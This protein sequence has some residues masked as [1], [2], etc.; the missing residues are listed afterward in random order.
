L[1]GD[2][3]GA[4]IAVIEAIDRLIDFK[5]YMV[6]KKHLLDDKG[7]R[8][9]IINGY[10]KVQT[11]FPDSF[12][13]KIYRRIEEM[14][15]NVGNLGNNILPLVPEIQAVFSHPVVHGVLTS[16]LG[17]NYVMHP[18][19]Y[20]HLNRPGSDGQNFHK[21]TYEGDEQVRRHRC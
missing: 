5:K 15:E 9:F 3:R 6:G 14:F 20:C 17:P 2:L 4:S 10:V 12:H 1:T 7:M 18:H 19:R 13:E 11:D 21:D 16:V 8:H